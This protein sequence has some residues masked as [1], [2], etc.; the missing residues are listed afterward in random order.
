M[1]SWLAADIHSRGKEA[2]Q[3]QTKAEERKLVIFCQVYAYV[4]M[5]LLSNARKVIL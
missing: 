4:L 2:V 3:M 5:M 1:P